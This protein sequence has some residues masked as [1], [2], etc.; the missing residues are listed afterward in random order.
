MNALKSG[1]H[2][3]SLVLPS[4]KLADLEELI[5]AYYAHHRPASPDA[6]ALVDDLI[7]CEWTLRRLD[8]AETQMWRFQGE[9]KFRDPEKFPLGKAATYNAS[10]FSKLQY[11][12]DAARR[13]RTRALQSLEKL[14]QEPAPPAEPVVEPDSLDSPDSLGSLDSPFPI[15]FVPPTPIAT[16]PQPSSRALAPTPQ[17]F[18]PP[19]SRLEEA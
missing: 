6:R 16:P 15:G 14:R 17:S 8:L 2:A 18:V 7:R 11:R 13:A 5:E 3:K 10:S 1:I 19:S 4:E 12:V 9:D